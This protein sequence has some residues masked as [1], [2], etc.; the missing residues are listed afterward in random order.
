MKLYATISSERATKGQGGN[1]YINIDLLV[2]SAKNPATAGSIS[3]FIDKEDYVITYNDDEIYRQSMP[4][5][6]GKQQKGETDKCI[7]IDG[8]LNR[9]CTAKIHNW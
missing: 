5:T 8:I 4:K 3:F 2:G 7:C 1:R 9:K 6:K